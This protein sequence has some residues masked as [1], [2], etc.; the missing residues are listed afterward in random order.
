MLTLNL[1]SNPFIAPKFGTIILVLRFKQEINT[2]WHFPDQQSRVSFYLLAKFLPKP[3]L[4]MHEAEMRHPHG[5][6]TEREREKQRWR[7][8]CHYFS[9]TR[10]LASCHRSKKGREMS[11]LSTK[12]LR[13]RI[14]SLG[15]G[16]LPWEKTGQVLSYHHFFTNTSPTFAASQSFK[17]DISIELDKVNWLKIASPQDWS[18]SCSSVHRPSL[19]P[20]GC[21]EINHP[22]GTSALYGLPTEQK[23]IFFY[24]SI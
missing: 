6:L 16:L 7:Q 19:D 15:F 9:M 17:W 13:L 21:C 2:I 4:H 3:N 20:L 24:Y 11:D 12:D 1:N 10:L 18:T 8:W 5:T 22:A 14:F 23:L